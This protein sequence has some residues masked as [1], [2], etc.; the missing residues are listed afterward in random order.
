MAHCNQAPGGGCALYCTTT[1]A[2]TCCINNTCLVHCSGACA[3]AKLVELPDNGGTWGCFAP[4]I[5]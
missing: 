1:I 4:G 2:G 3:I 5:E